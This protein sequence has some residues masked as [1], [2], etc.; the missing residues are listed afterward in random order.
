MDEWADD[1]ARNT[2][3]AFEA[4]GYSVSALE[5]IWVVG[6]MRG[7]KGTALCIY[8]YNSTVPL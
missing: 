3:A 8:M 1:R 2:E 5:C 6:T 7:L 4:V